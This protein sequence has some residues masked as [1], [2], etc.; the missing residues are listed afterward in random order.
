MTIDDQEEK[1]LRS[2]RG[3]IGYNQSQRCD[4]LLYL[5]VYPQ[6]PMVKTRVGEVHCEE[7]KTFGMF[8]QL[9]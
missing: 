8:R 9:N 4:T 2:S 3:A 6:R 5:L 7:K 1:S